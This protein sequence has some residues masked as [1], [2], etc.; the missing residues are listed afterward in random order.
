MSGVNEWFVRLDKGRQEAL[1][2]NK[3]TLAD[4]VWDEAVRQTA[5]R[6][7][8]ITQQHYL[9]NE[10]AVAIDAKIHKEFSV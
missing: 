5:K 1:R 6:C 9:A 10:P 7:K 3:W 8:E 4:A 2:E